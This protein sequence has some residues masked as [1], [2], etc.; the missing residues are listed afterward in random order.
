MKYLMVYLKLLLFGGINSISF[1]RKSSFWISVCALCMEAKACVCG[2]TGAKNETNLK[3]IYVSLCYM[4]MINVFVIFY[5]YAMNVKIYDNCF[6]IIKIITI[7]VIITRR[8]HI[9]LTVVNYQCIHV[10][11][12]CES[13]FSL[14]IWILYKIVIKWKRFNEFRLRNMKCATIR[15]KILFKCHVLH[16]FFFVFFFSFWQCAQNAW[17]HVN[18]TTCLLISKICNSVNIFVLFW[19]QL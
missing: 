8:H 11:I 10:Y 16:F 14:V 17:I 2:V 13:T 7:I 18:V 3:C 1:E 5:E 19:Y 12:V 4:H 15:Y 9:F 6:S